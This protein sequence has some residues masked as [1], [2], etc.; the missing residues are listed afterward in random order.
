MIVCCLAFGAGGAFAQSW[1]SDSLPELGD[2]ASA[3]IS[4]QLEKKIGQE[5]MTNIRQKDPSFLDD[6]EVEAYLNRIGNRLAAASP[7]PGIGFYFF[8]LNDPMINAFATFG[9]FVGVNSGL[10]LAVRNESELAGVLAHEISHVTQHHLARGIVRQQQLSTATLL[11]VAVAILAAHSNPD[12]AVAAV[13][14]STAGAIQTQ[15]GYSRDFERE[16]DRIGLQTLT[17]AGFDTRSMSSF[18]SRLQQATRAYENNAPA[19]LRTHP[20]N[21]ERIS[22]MQNREQ[23]LPYRQHVDSLEF[24]L[25]RARLDAMRGTPDEAVARFSQLLAG[26]NILENRYGLAVAQARKKDWAA[27]ENTLTATPKEN[28]EISPLIERLHAEARVKQGNIDGGLAA[29]KAALARF[30]EARALVYSYAESLLETRHPEEALRFLEQSVRKHNQD[31]RLYKLLAQANAQTGHPGA[32]HQ[33]LAEAYVLEGALPAA[34]EQ[35]ELAQKSPGND[36]YRASAI[37]AR[38]RELKKRQQ[39]AA[40]AAL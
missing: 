4:P 10:I 18:F 27:V 6:P 37:D 3:L 8:P 13:A 17:K 34:I 1:G 36:F 22:D 24:R 29:F 19:Y 38:L 7:N 26:R 16:A 9:G 25:V 11:A 5:I 40:R 12:V 30:P 33:A 35:L 15:L 21:T 2:S 23:A 14:G 39:E 31:A 32:Q 28:K 20:L